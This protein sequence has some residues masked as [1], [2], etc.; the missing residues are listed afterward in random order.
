S[1]RNVIQ[2]VHLHASFAL[3]ATVA[4]AGLHAPHVAELDMPAPVAVRAKE[5]HT[6]FDE[7]DDWLQPPAPT[8]GTV[9]ERAADDRRLV[10]LRSLRGAHRCV[11]HG[12]AHRI[13]PR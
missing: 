2:R 9:G 11:L 5:S 6:F 3:G 12:G 13:L 7:V 10:A 1:A 8:R 4:R